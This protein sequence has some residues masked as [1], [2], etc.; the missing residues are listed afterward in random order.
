MYLIAAE[1]AMNQSRN[2]DAAQYITDLRVRA[3]KP[4]K[5][6]QM[7]VAAGD[8]DLNFILEERAKE[9]AGEGFRWYDLKRTG[10]LLDRVKLYNK[11]AAPNIKEFHL[12]RPIPQTQ[13]DRVSNPGDFLQNPGY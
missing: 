12:L 1:A 9:L 6:A 10:T 4:G 13:I 3:I 2:S 7:A 5:E 11:D 8:I